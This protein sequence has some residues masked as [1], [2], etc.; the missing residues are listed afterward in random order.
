MRAS[1]GVS[2]RR[3]WGITN[4]LSRWHMERSNRIPVLR[5]SVPVLTGIA[6][7]DWWAEPF[8]SRG[9]LTSSPLRARRDFLPRS[10]VVS[11][12][13]SDS[14]RHVLFANRPGA[15]SGGSTQYHA[16]RR[17]G[18]SFLFDIRVSAYREGGDPKLAVMVTDAAGARSREQGNR[19]AHRSC[20]QRVT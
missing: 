4:V 6:V 8:F 20:W 17:N 7:V 9:V 13:H 1:E 14:D 10:A 19:V 16:R 18:E 12:W 15:A 11:C 2:H 3:P 5:S